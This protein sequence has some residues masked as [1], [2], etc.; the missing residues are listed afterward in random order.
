MGVNNFNS[1]ALEDSQRHLRF[2]ETDQ[3]CEEALA[4]ELDGTRGGEFSLDLDPK[5]TAA[6][7]RIIFPSF[8]YAKEPS[9]LS[10]SSRWGRRVN[11]DGS[12]FSLSSTTISSS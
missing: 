3:G 7:T 4:S 12:R 11:A 1:R 10:D 9:L 8:S 5:A 6:G 2:V